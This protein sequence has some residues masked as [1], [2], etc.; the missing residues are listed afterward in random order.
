MVGLALR[1]GMALQAL[2]ALGCAIRPWS[3]DA[4]CRFARRSVR[5]QSASSEPLSATRYPMAR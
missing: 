3:A 2:V 5:G 4:A 1:R